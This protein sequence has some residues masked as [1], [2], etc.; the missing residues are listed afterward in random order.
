MITEATRLLHQKLKLA[1]A[2]LLRRHFS[3][4]IVLNDRL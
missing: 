4:G 3:S 1:E 2:A